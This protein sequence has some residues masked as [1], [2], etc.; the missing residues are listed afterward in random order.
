MS[1]WFEFAFLSSNEVEHLPMNYWAIC[2]SSTVKGPLPASQP[3]CFPF[4]H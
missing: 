3:E 2:V 1:V 4:T